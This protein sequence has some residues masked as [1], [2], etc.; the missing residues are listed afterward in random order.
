MMK[1][2][3]ESVGLLGRA[4]E[5]ATQ[6]IE[7]YRDCMGGKGQAEVRAAHYSVEKSGGTYFVQWSFV[8]GL[9]SMM[10]VFVSYSTSKNNYLLY[11]G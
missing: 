4:E 5:H 9:H 1:K 7:L 2:W 3:S 11:D 6:A 10:I 8:E